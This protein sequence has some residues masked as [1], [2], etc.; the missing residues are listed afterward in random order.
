M[1]SPW[2][3]LLRAGRYTIF[4]G[5]EWNQLAAWVFAAREAPCVVFAETEGGAALIPAAISRQ[6][7]TLLGE[8]LFDYRDVLSTGDGEA[9]S[10]AWK[11]LADMQTGDR[12]FSV[13]G[14]RGSSF[15]FGLQSRREFDTGFFAN[16]PGVQAQ[17]AN[18]KSRS[19]LV[20]NIE[21]MKAEGCSLKV[22]HGQDISLVRNI[23]QLKAAQDK[24][25][26]FQ[27]PLRIEMACAMAQTS[28]DACEIFTL[29]NGA[30]I[31]AA[32]ITFI[33]RRCRRLYATYYNP[34]WSR[35]S[36]G[37]SLLHHVIQ[38]S[39]EAGMDVDLMTGEQPYKQRFATCKEPLYTLTASAAMLDEMGSAVGQ[40]K[41]TEEASLAA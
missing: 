28:G 23:F 15:G 5:F 12:T 11:T 10:L 37:V 18:A 3:E 1:K 32:L 30:T 41:N 33:D 34:A 9:L 22:S 36:P 2:Q 17:D 39:L 14:V 25:S 40:S 29:L 38:R 4:Q 27:D 31:I 21:R 6:H 8:E 19:R 13:K 26:L 16:A 7:L 35:Y 20:R 24:S